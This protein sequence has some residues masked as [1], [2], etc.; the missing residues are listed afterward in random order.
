MILASPSVGVSTRD[1]T[2][3]L[4][5]INAHASDTSFLITYAR[6]LP[7]ADLSEVAVVSWSWGDRSS[8]VGAARDPRID[9]VAELDGSM[10]YYTGLVL[11]TPGQKAICCATGALLPA[12]V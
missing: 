1:M 3:D 8:L 12:Q 2:D 7:D 6:S 4:D 9:A 11:L 10:R 5:E